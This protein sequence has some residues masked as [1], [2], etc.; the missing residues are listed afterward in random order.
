MWASMVNETYG[1]TYHFD[2]LLTLE[3]ILSLTIILC[4]GK[5]LLHHPSF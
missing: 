2:L 3:L 1:N 4:L 5:E